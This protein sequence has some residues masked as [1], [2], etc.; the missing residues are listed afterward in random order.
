MILFFLALCSILLA[1]GN[2]NDNKALV[3]YVHPSYFE[4]KQDKIQKFANWSSKPDIK[5]CHHAP[6]TILQVKAALKW[7]ENLG[8]EFGYV[9]R[10]ACIENANYGNIVISLAGQD[11]KFDKNYGTTNVHHD[12]KTG[13]T[14]WAQIFLPEKV[15][16][17]V[18][19]H[20][21]GHALGWHHTTQK[22]HILYPS[23][24]LG[25]WNSE[26]LEISALNLTRS[27]SSSKNP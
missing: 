21:I 20:E 22:G 12:T 26:G 7:W 27:K 14:H 15:R 17:R 11:F 10:S 13:K 25:G 8:Y 3:R 1:S 4:I 2:V 24:Q 19:E 5:I 9:Y 6:V 23:W 18:L 16:E